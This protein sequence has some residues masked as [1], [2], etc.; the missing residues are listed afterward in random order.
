MK[1]PSASFAF[2]TASETLSTFW[3][4]N[5][6]YELAHVHADRLELV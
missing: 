1:T 2:Y 3:N 5:R 4:V 6:P